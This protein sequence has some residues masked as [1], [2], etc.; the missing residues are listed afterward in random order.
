MVHARASDVLTTTM[1][2]NPPTYFGINGVGMLHHPKNTA[3]NNR[4]FALVAELGIKWDR[5]DLWW[6]EFEKKPGRWTYT[7]GDAAMKAY[8]EHGVQMLPILDY[9]AAWLDTRAPSNQQERAEFAQYVTNVVSR[10][11][12]YAGYWEVWNEPNIIPFWR[13]QP[14]AELYA[15]LLRL[16]HDTIHT[17]DPDSKTIAFALAD[18]DHEFLERVLEIAGAD[19]F[20][21]VSYHFYRTSEPE[22]R[23]LEEIAE[24]KLTLEHF[25]RR[26]V[27]VWVTEMGVTSHLGN[28][29]VSEDM[30][31][32]YLMRQILLLIAGGAERVFPFCLVDNVSDPGGP[33]GSQLGMVTLD[34]RKKPVFYAYKTMIAQLQDY[35]LAGPVDLGENVYSYLFK[36]RNGTAGNVQHKLVAWTTHDI[37]D[38]RVTIDDI[39]TTVPQPGTVS[40]LQPIPPE[41]RNYT[42]NLGEKRALEFH[43]ATARVMLSPAPIYMPVKSAELEKN[44]NTQFRPS[45]ISAAPGQKYAARLKRAENNPVTIT[46]TSSASDVW[47]HSVAEEDPTSAEI[48][49]TVPEDTR[50][51][52]YTIRANVAGTSNTV[53]KS[54]RVWV[55]DATRVQV[56]PFCTSATQDLVTS[57]TV[58][59]T[60][61]SDSQTYRFTSEP[62]LEEITFPSGTVGQNTT[63]L[64]TG[65][66]PEKY[67]PY[68]QQAAV[69]IP[70]A[71]LV[72]LNDTLQF[73]LN[74][75]PV[76]RIGVLSLRERAPLV[77]ALLMEYESTPR[78]LLNDSTQVLAGEWRK[79][80]HDIGDT[81][82]SIATI[83]TEEGLYL[84]CEIVD[85]HPMMNDRAAGQDI[86]KGDGIEVYLCPG[87]YWGQYYANKENG[88]YH[89]ALS[90]GRNGD[91]TLV[92]DFEDRVQG[93]KIAVRRTKIG[94]NMEAFIPKSAFGNYTAK[95]GDVIGWD[96]QLNDRDDYS[97]AARQKALM[98]NGDHMNWLRAGKWGMAVIR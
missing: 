12:G 11:K 29:G 59:N 86:Y 74:D 61:L 13:P 98:W 43:G 5:S 58:H 90:P 48:R 89:F 78:L 24:L 79:S 6:S 87:G 75:R 64:W 76:Y 55:R 20:D 28:E 4:R 31:A 26:D 88:A 46:G 67:N 53:A 23:T 65:D 19:C 8:R 3:E 44:A 47:E 32:I 94:C 93:S 84:G 39:L 83:W 15:P 30:Q 77:D 91:G 38:I 10:Y 2:L 57:F 34:W 50:P 82:A 27:P 21:A 70:R 96:V 54:L 52:W 63:G 9:G 69:T 18:L 71:Q 35:E 66:K 37:K 92:S 81:S 33:W 1:P 22:K 56:R 72:K 80:Q 49:F 85:D 40:V 73:K 60:G 17:A 95:H 68:F 62:V 97:H 25:G 14:S 42:T 51:G 45:A 16:T 7:L 36:L 41:L